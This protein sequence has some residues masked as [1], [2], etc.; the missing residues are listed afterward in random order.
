METPICLF[1][2]TDTILGFWWFDIAF[3]LRL[4][5]E[6]LQQMG[7][8]YSDKSPTNNVN[9]YSGMNVKIR[10]IRLTMSEN[11]RNA[12]H[13]CRGP[14]KI[15]RIQTGFTGG[16]KPFNLCNRELQKGHVKEWSRKPC[17]SH[18]QNMNFSRGKKY[19]VPAEVQLS[20]SGPIGRQSQFLDIPF[21]SGSSQKV[22][23]NGATPEWMV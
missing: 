19:P 15:E 5:L 2:H 18:A 20:A 14:S 7:P 10:L 12:P 23:I 9:R 6:I 21:G 13:C 3:W 11:D 16:G 1:Y 22:S 8:V 17:Q 4:K